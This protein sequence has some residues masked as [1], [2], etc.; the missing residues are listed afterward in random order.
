MDRTIEVSKGSYSSAVRPAA[1]WGLL[2][3]LAANMLIDALEVSIMV[4][5]MPVIAEDL[6]ITVS[7]LSGS[8]AGSRVGSPEH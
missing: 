8:S 4:V 7:P 6:A 1:A 5:A 2:A 3:L